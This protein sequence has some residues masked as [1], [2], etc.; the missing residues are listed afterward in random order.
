[1]TRRVLA[2]FCWVFSLCWGVSAAPLLLVHEGEGLRPVALWIN[3]DFAAPPSQVELQKSMGSS[4]LSTQR[5]FPLFL[6]G[7]IQN[8]FYPQGFQA[9]PEHCTSQGLWTG[10]IER[11]VTRPLLSMTSDFPGSKRY[12]GNYPDKSMLAAAVPLAQKAFLSKGFQKK[13]LQRFRTR[14]R[15]A[16]T[17]NNGTRYFV[18]IEAEITH[19]RNPCPEASALVIVEK[20]GRRYLQRLL[21]FRRNQ[22][23]CGTYRFVSS[24]STDTRTN[25]ILVQGIA[26]GARWYDIYAWQNDRF[27]QR[28]HGAGH[29]CPPVSVSEGD[30]PSPDKSE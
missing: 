6:N 1:M 25:H 21:N 20:V 3:E 30:A 24:F 11:S 2:V 9:K 17:L 28:F 14:Q 15:T 23:D 13:D 16:F 29:N 4:L 12:A 26:N 5:E 18:A 7:E 27:L 8:H 22:A 19:P 10:N